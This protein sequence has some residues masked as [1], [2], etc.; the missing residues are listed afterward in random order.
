MHAGELR[1]FPDGSQ[2]AGAR[3]V[4]FVTARAAFWFEEHLRG[5]GVQ[6]GHDLHGTVWFKLPGR[7]LRRTL[8]SNR[9]RQ[10]ARGVIAVAGVEER[11]IHFRSSR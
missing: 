3:G 4:K 7:V 9:G 2:V 10:N 1:E 5:R 11:E 6:T 8:D